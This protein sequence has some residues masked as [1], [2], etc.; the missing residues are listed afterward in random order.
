MKTSLGLSVLLPCYNRDCVAQIRLLS[1]QVFL[2]VQEGVSI[3]VLVLEDGSTQDE[4]ITANARA[5]QAAGFRHLARATNCGLAV[6]RN[7]LMRL[8]C[9]EWLLLMDCDLFPPTDFLAGYVRLL[10][11]V[12]RAQV[13]CG[14]LRKIQPDFPS[15]RYA[16]ETSSADKRAEETRRNIPYVALSCANILL[17]KEV[18]KE[19]MFDERYRTYGYEDVDFGR[20][21]RLRNIPILY[22]DNPVEIRF[23]ESNQSYVKK[24]EESLRT[25]FLFRKELEQ[26][27]YLIQYL[28][29][30]RRWIP[31]A[32]LCFLAH[33]LT[34]LLK[35]LL[36]GKC[37]YWR[38]LNPYKMFYYIRLGG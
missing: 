30:L 27:V 18:T 32:F 25:L 5:C 34:P 21:L 3:E 29:G 38:L 4:R 9:H 26:D 15:L 14:G 20:Q 23:F 19:V 2:L 8:A 16:Y 35:K 7:E 10:R 1:E 22:I 36:V 13:V 6:T 12:P 31:N 24:V 37:V 11:T 28:Y 33:F 17:H